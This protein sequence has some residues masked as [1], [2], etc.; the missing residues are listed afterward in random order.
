MNSSR[1]PRVKRGNKT[2]NV[3]SLR[4]NYSYALGG[5]ELADELA[6]SL[7]H[8][9][10]GPHALCSPNQQQLQGPDGS[11]HRSS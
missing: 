2:R 9:S 7:T 10:C 1:T 3:A 5:T 8:T 11:R 4:T 6:F